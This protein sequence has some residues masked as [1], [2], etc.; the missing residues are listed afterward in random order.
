[1]SWVRSAHHVFGIEHLLGE[2]SNV[3]VSVLLGSSGSQR[4]ESDH[5]EV[6][7]WE[8]YQVGGEFSQVRVELTWESETASDS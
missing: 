7:S 1:M 2:L 8:W 4:S 6:E 5:E 3:E